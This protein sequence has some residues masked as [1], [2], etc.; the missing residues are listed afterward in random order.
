MINDVNCLCKTPWIH[1]D[2][3][4]SHLQLYLFD[5]YDSMNCRMTNMA[6]KW[7]CPRCL[8]DELSGS[9]RPHSEKRGGCWTWFGDA[10]S[11]LCFL[12]LVRKL[13]SHHPSSHVFFLENRPSSKKLYVTNSFICPRPPSFHQILDVQSIPQ[14]CFLGNPLHT[15]F[16]LS[17]P[18]CI[19]DMFRKKN[20]ASWPVCLFFWARNPPIERRSYQR[21]GRNSMA[22]LG[23][24]A[25]C[26]LQEVGLVVT[27]HQSCSKL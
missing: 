25:N 1:R 20:H 17:L 9:I 12:G 6:G 11:Q 18:H 19:F 5:I 23:V 21:S 27:S 10:F 3:L 13:G 22:F 16:Y 14:T 15:F 2:T 7:R 26:Q 8:A 24:W 4:Y